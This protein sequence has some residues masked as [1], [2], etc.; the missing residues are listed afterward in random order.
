MWK[1]FTSLVIE[2]KG[3]HVLPWKQGGHVALGESTQDL[4]AEWVGMLGPKN[5]EVDGEEHPTTLSVL[6]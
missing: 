2:G 3:Q 5:G 1:F 4:S 6:V